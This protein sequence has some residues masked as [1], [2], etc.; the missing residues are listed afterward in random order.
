MNTEP[1]AIDFYRYPPIGADD[2]QYAYA[3]AK[4]RALETVMLSRT[5]LSEIAH[6][7]RFE[8]AAE[9]LS[10]TEY[11]VGPQ[12]SAGE[13]EEMLLA[14]RREVRQLFRQLMS[15]SAILQMF[16]AREDFVNM[17][18]AVRR[19]VTDKPLGSGYSPEGTVPAEEF[20]EIFKQ[21]NYERLPEYL[22]E[23]VEAAVLSYYENKDIRQIDYAIDRV[24][25]AWRIRH[26]LATDCI[27][28]LSLSR[29]R[30]DLYNIRTLLRLKAAGRQDE[31][32]LFLPDGF[33]ERDK[34]IQG[35]ETSY[36]SL[37]PLFYATPYFELM[38]EGVR[39]LREKESFLALERGC[40]DY[41]TGFLK[42]TRVVTAGPQ[43]PAAYLLMKETEIRTVRMLLIGKK[44]GLSTELLMERLGTWMD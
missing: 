15:D 34:F 8:A 38:E 2:W 1:V 28:C 10:G 14:R 19:V 44:N 35:L 4:V 12:A 13:I 3:T 27:F 37:A 40:E 33:V 16:L 24:E 43:P 6:A 7:E 22:Q 31:R 20:E 23:G 11:A 39:Y 29:A 9:V 17:R 26:S 32:F 30:I 25:A 42:S 18:L 41:L 5:T 21:E 36:E